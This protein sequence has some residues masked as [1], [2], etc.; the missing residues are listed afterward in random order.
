MSEEQFHNAMTAMAAGDMSALRQIYD[1]YL[2]LIYAICLKVLKHREAAEDV[3]SEFFIRLYRS[4]STFNGQGHHKTWMA[5]IAKNMCIDYI[6]KNN[7]VTES[8]DAAMTPEEGEAAREPEDAKTVGGGSVE[9]QTVNRITIEWA[10]E[11]LTEKER[12]IMD[13][14]CGGGFTFR[15]IAETL[16]MPQGTV[17][18]HYNNAVAKLRKLIGSSG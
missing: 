11:Q 1:A 4:A 13:L 16:G 9:E 6:R 8:I 18:W 2:K 14:K 12:E 5:T 10:R 17:S 3:T 7:R 15:E